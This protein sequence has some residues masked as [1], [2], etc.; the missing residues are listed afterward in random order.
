MSLPVE[1]TPNSPVRRRAAERDDRSPSDAVARVL[2]TDYATRLGSYD[3]AGD[4]LAVEERGALRRMP[5][6]ATELTDVT[7]VE[8][9]QLRLERVVLI[10]VWTAGTL[11]DAQ[12]SMAEL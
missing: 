11:A 2:A 7:E 10:G 5:G 6:L 8:Y 9:R 12:T 1:S 3:D 4:E